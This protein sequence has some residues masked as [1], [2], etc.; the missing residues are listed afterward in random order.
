MKH[1]DKIVL[2]WVLFWT[3]FLCVQTFGVEAQAQAVSQETID[4]MDDLKYKSDTWL[5]IVKDWW[6]LLAVPVGG[7][8]SLFIPKVRELLARGIHKTADTSKTM[9]D[10]MTPKT[11]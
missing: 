10:K 8:L 1:L 2:F 5:Q 4:E 3:V 9:A 7:L 11:K 6:G